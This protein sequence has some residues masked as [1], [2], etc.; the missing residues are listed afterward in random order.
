MRGSTYGKIIEGVLSHFVTSLYS[1]VCSPPYCGV[2]LLDPRLAKYISKFMVE[3]GF[4][5]T[6]IISLYYPKI[7][8]MS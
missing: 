7:I 3:G 6:K 5:D 1:K 4:Y 8:N 2:V